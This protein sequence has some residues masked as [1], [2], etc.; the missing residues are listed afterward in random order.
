MKIAMIL[1]ASDNEVIGKNNQLPWHIPA[2]L[3]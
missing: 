2:E 1:A 3:K